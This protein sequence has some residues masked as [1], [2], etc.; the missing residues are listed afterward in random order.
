LPF[1]GAERGRDRGEEEE[2]EW[3]RGIMKSFASFCIIPPTRALSLSLSLSL[4]PSLSFFEK[5]LR[6]DREGGG[7]G[8]DLVKYRFN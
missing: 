2:A 1:V 3:H 4:S 5:A 7:G 8:G 6:A